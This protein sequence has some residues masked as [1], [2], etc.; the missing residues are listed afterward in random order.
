MGLALVKLGVGAASSMSG[1][2]FSPRK[3]QAP[4]D[5]NLIQGGVLSGAFNLMLH[6]LFFF[7]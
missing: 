5:I 1:F 6:P 2:T 7:I 4:G 3:S